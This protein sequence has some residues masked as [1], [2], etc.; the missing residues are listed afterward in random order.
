MII[1][2]S[3]LLYDTQCVCFL[4]GQP[5]RSLKWFWHMELPCHHAITPRSFQLRL[6]YLHIVASDCDANRCKLTLQ[7]HNL[8]LPSLLYPWSLSSP[9]RLSSHFAFVVM[10]SIHVAS[11]SSHMVP[12]SRKVP[13]FDPT[14][15]QRIQ[16]RLFSIRTC[17]KRKLSSSWP[18]QLWKQ[19]CKSTSLPPGTPLCIVWVFV[20]AWINQVLFLNLLFE[21]DLH[22]HCVP[23]T[24]NGGGNQGPVKKSYRHF[25]RRH[26]EKVWTIPRGKGGFIRTGL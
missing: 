7:R 8:L 23:L 4:C 17:E 15:A 21:V 22:N 18:I 3:L 10:S 2:K 25:K 11:R 12:P 9:I 16:V 14:S 6:F 26:V 19:M 5:T 13:P 1:E 24:S 20:I